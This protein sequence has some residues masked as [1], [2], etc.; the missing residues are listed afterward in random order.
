MRETRRNTQTS[1]QQETKTPLSVYDKQTKIIMKRKT[2][3][4]VKDK[5]NQLNAMAIYQTLHTDSK[6]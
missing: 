1:K 5:T 3:E 6:E 4:D 2:I